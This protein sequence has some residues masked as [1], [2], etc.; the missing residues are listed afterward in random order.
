MRREPDT[1]HLALAVPECFRKQ[2]IDGLSTLALHDEMRAQGTHVGDPGAFYR[3]HGGLH[4]LRRPCRNS[5]IGPALA[6]TERMV[7][8][9]DS[10]DEPEILLDEL[11]QVRRA[12][13]PRRGAL[14]E[15]SLHL[16]E[17]QRSGRRSSLARPRDEIGIPLLTRRCPSARYAHGIYEH[18]GNVAVFNIE[19]SD[20]DQSADF[21]FRVP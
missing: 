18:G 21:L 17:N 20:G 5:P 1:A 9:H 10:S 14:N 6:D 12:A 4:G 19:Q 8:R 16:P 2:N 11:W 15:A 7:E 13:A 3:I